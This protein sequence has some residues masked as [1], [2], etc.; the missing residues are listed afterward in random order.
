[1]AVTIMRQ[2]A[3]ETLKQVISEPSTV[4]QLRNEHESEVLD[5]LAARPA[6]TVVMAGLIRDNG[7]VNSLNRG[8]FYACRDHQ[9]RL[10]GVALIG[11]LTIIETRSET[12]LTTFARLARN[13]TTTRLIRGERE[14]MDRFWKDYTDDGSSPRLICS[15]YLLEQRETLRLTELVE[16]LRP[17][18]LTN[19]EQVMKINAA[20]AFEE[21]GASPLDLDPQGFCN[22]T[23]RR[24]EQGRVWT[25]VRD[26]KLVFKADIISETPEAIYLEGVHVDSEERRKGFGRRCLNQLGSI[27]LSKTESICLTINE[28]NHNALAFYKRAGYRFL[29][30][31]ET[32]YLR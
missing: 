13:C 14:T 7:L 5:F 25:C 15:E 1:M 32:I 28:R 20:M 12:S 2:E 29:S 10:E 21:G 19:L 3:V 18:T 23:A 24:I 11:H 26:G 22:R 4:A 30:H 6:H 17:A 27:L 8:A 31:Y 16:N 9:G